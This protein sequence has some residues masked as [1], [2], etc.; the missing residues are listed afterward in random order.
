M[1]TLAKSL[2]V[3]M[4]FCAAGLSS[5]FGNLAFAASPENLMARLASG[6]TVVE[7]HP[8]PASPWPKIVIHKKISA[9]PEEVLKLF[10]AYEK[11]TRFAKNLRS[12]EILSVS[13][14]KKTTRVRYTVNVPLLP[15]IQYEVNNTVSHPDSEK[16]LIEWVRVES[17]LFSR[18][19]GSL[20]IKPHEGGTIVRYESLVVPS[21]GLVTP[22][23]GFVVKEAREIM[24]NFSALA[25]SQSENRMPNHHRQ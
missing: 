3:A 19:E 21:T 1:T 6:E 20:L 23:R 7:E 16:H 22:L 25:E 12:A 8:L 9:Q 14:N 15:D 11:S 17:D 2:T 13:P 18:I 5:I 4:A 24:E 10:S